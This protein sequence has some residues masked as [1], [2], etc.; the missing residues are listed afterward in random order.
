LPDHIGLGRSDKPA[1][2]SDYTF[3]R[4]VDWISEFVGRLDLTD[5]TYFGQDWGSLIGLTVV[6]RHPGRFRGIVLG[7]GGLPNPADPDASAR[8]PCPHPTPAPSAPGRRSPAT[9]P[10]T[11]SDACFERAS[12]A[13]RASASTSPTPKPPP[14]THRSPTPATRPVL[15]T[16]DKPLVCRFGR[17]DPILGWFDD[18]MIANVPGASGQP[19]AIFPDG[20]HFIQAQEPDA[21]VDAIVHVVNR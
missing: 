12:L 3:R 16:W 21:L 6:A 1:E 19:R 17:A 7:N 4:H 9:P 20:G 2:G 18:H 13:S 11:T 14:T 10:G 8:P 5:V 15:S